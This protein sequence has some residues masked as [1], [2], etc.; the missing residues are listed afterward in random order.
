MTVLRITDFADLDTYRLMQ[1][2]YESNLENTDYFYPDELDKDVAVAKVESGF[3]AFLENEFFNMP[4][5]TY[6]VLE[7]DGIWLSALRTVRV[8]D[9]TYYLEA[10][11]TRPDSRQKGYGSNLLLSVLQ[12][13][14]KQGPFKICDCVSKKNIASL[15]THEK[16]GFKIVSDK[17]YN[18]LY[19][20]TDEHDFGLEFVHSAK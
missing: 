15:K 17:G 13:M 10:L 18:Y 9:G 7:S 1:V 20:E 6:W 5:A 4:N 16:C 2:Y 14:K 19:G 8:Q 12:T 3:I 11:E